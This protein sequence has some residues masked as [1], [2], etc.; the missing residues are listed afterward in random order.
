MS[1]G[2]RGDLLVQFQNS[3]GTPL[4]SSQFAV[5][6][7][8]EGLRWQEAQL[9]EGNMY[10]RFAE[11]PRHRGPWSIAGD[12]ALDADP[13]GMGFALRS[14]LGQSVTTSGTNTSAH[15]MEPRQVDFDAGVAALTPL[16]AEVNRDVGSAF[17]YSDLL[18]NTLGL[19]IRHG[20]LLG[21]TWGLVGA[22]FTRKAAATP[23]FAV[24]P[25]FKWDQ[26]SFNWNAVA[27]TEVRDLSLTVN[28]N[29]EAVHTLV[30]SRS[31][32]KIMRGG[33]QTVELTG[34]L[35]FEQHSYF[36]W[37]D[38]GSEFPM[39]LHLAGQ[40]PSTLLIDMPKV[41]LLSFEP[42]VAGPGRV[43][44]A[45]TARAMYHVSSLTAIRFTLTNCQRYYVPADVA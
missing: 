24:T 9:E 19:Q 29:L 21:A 40:A 37:Y 44:A 38:A 8:R 18:G 31:P 39:T 20:Q 45:F 26:C 17:Q 4:T 43:E 7:L 2:M 6:F 22:G 23:S 30:A 5:P 28:N 14:V 35:A 25:P 13:R 33:M 15:V 34:T 3:Y 11:G 36:D 41:R 10:Q 12:V 42:V 27:I 1:Y 32:R 16:T